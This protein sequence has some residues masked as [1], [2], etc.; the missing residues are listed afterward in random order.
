MS[1]SPD[2]GDEIDLDEG[3]MTLTA[4]DP[5]M[6]DLIFMNGTLDVST[7]RGDQVRGVKVMDT[8]TVVTGPEIKELETIGVYE[9]A[10]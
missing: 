7:A 2:V 5:S 4:D 3:Y 10:P 1:L 8:V 6:L 9:D